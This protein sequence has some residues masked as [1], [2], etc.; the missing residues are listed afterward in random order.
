MP[1]DTSLLFGA[2][3]RNTAFISLCERAP[4]SSGFKVLAVSRSGLLPPGIVQITTV[5]RVETEIVNE[6]K[7]CGLGIRRITGNRE[8]DSPLSS[9]RNAFLKEALCVDVVKYLD[10]GTPDLLSDP[11]TIGRAAIDCPNA[12]IAKLGM[13][14]AY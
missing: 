5:H 7:H 11:L 10:Y 8:S 9:S 1:P 2:V 12:P 6:A 4:E 13:V 3:F 14:V